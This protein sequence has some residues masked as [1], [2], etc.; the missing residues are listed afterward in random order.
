MV[1]SFDLSGHDAVVRAKQRR[2]SHGIYDGYEEYKT[3]S[4]EDY[5]QVLTKGMVVPDTNTLLNLYRY[6]KRTRNDLIAI[7]ERVANQ[8]WMPRQVL[9]EFWRNR[10][11]ALDDSKSILTETTA[12]LRALQQKSA[13]AVNKWSNRLALS[14]ENLDSIRDSL[15]RGFEV[16]INRVQKLTEA[17][18]FIVSENTNDD[19]VLIAL[20]PLFGGRIGPAFDDS[21]VE[22]LLAEANR[23]IQNKIPPGYEDKDKKGGFPAGDYFVWEQ[24]IREAEERRC[25]VLII[26]GDKKKDW[27]QEEGGKRK[28]PRLELIRELRQRAQARLFMLRPESLLQYAK[29]VL[30]VEVSQKSVEDAGRVDRL[31][32]ALELSSLTIEEVGALDT[33]AEDAVGGYLLAKLPRDQNGDYLE[34]VFDMAQL[35]SSSPKL[36]AYLDAFQK[37]FPNITLR[38][39]ARRRMRN[40]ESLGLASVI[41]NQ[42][43]LTP[44]GERFVADGGN[45]ELLQISFLR[46]INGAVTI[47]DMAKEESPRKLRAKLAGTPPQ[48]VSATQAMLTLRWLEQ[49]NLIES[50]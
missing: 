32:A 36:E 17:E 48:G 37:R 33:L 26:T 46:R 14:G 50:L 7:L 30:N 43:R 18:A 3:A 9:D 19:P 23:R 20:E 39:E 12:E 38:T 13:E 25:D 6:N 34:T 41:K 27:W 49:L 44:L 29:S 45:L 47:L 28:G 11:N 22:A 4:D 16:A 15:K 35:A 2:S 8:L 21:E 40:L 31:R 24:I 10:K 5:R 42:V 1:P